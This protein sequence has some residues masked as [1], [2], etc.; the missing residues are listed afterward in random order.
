MSKTLQITSCLQ[1]PFHGIE[2]DPSSDDSFDAWDEALVCKKTKPSKK[3]LAMRIYHEGDDSGRI[4][5]GA[6]RNPEREYKG[7]GEP[8]PEWCPL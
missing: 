3:E 8:I 5:V 1:C 7:D 6:S 4:I 2:R